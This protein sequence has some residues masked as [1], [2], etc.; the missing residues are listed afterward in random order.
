MTRVLMLLSNPFTH[1]PRLHY[2]ACALVDRGYEVTVLAWDRK[3]VHPA[4]EERDGVRVVRVRN[5]RFMEALRYDLFRLRLWWS[6]AF[7]RALELHRE[8]PFDVIHAHDLDTL[9]AG[10]RLKKR[11]N[12]PLIYD[13]HEIWGYMV[14]KDLPGFLVSHFLRMERRLVRH[15][16]QIITV[17]EPL[18]EYFESISRVPVAVVMNARPPFVT[19]YT[20]P[21]NDVM[22]LL[23]IGAL[24]E[25]RFV[26]GIIEAMDGLE[27]VRCVIGGVGKPDYVEMLRKRAVRAGNVDFVGRVPFHD[28]LPMTL[29]SDVIL[30]MFD[31]RDPLTRI[32]LPNK[33]FEAMACG[34]PL[35]ASRGTYVGRFV[36]ELGFGV[37]AE[38]SVGGLRE[39]VIALRD[40][41]GLRERLGRRAL[42]L[43]K[44]EYG[45][46]SQV[47]T[48]VRVYETLQR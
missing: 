25:T 48:L 41:P 21:E 38:Y 47:R 12:I 27:G 39:A 35:I 46:E 2:E 8:T 44:G 29:R 36:E 5:T 42:E 14:A 11:L 43:A 30:A 24:N 10:L 32:G 26:D 13:A 22:T 9:P 15:V 37:T 34:R 18:R 31:P 28:V 45:W 16:D 40:D 1:D 23:Y 7:R 4:E 17:S 33:A 6:L 20:P 3:G 19:E